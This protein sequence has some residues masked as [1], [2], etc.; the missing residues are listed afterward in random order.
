MRSCAGNPRRCPT[1]GYLP[2][3]HAVRLTGRT[4]RV[5]HALVYPPTHPAA[6]AP[7]GELP[8]YMVWAHG[9]PTSHVIGLLDLEKA[10]FTSRGIG[11]I[12]VNYGGSTGYGR[13]YRERLRMQWGVVDVEDVMTAALA[14][15]EAGRPTGP[16]W[17]SAAARRAAGPRWPR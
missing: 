13:N 15:A 5:V 6:A 17:A 10:Y 16:G 8:P 9:G 14:L 3:P 12:D 1:R 2:V 11:I 4:A 7:D